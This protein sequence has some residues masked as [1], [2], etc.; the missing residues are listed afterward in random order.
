[1]KTITKTITAFITGFT[2]LAG[3]NAVAEYR[4]DF[5]NLSHD[6]RQHDAQYYDYYPK[7]N[8][9]RDTSYRG[10][11]SYRRDT[12]YRRDNRYSRPRSRVVNRETYSTRYR[13]KIV[14]VEE[15]YY[16]RSGRKQLVC[17]IV[18]K[19][20]EAYYI[21]RQRLQRIANKGCSRYS[22]IQYL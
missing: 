12:S 22:R 10:D 4:P 11:N 3:A 5:C 13:A 19:G 15:V 6:H 2:M 18:P 20:P 21:K 7:D 16:T 1:M 14:L 8:Y 9:Y 17:S